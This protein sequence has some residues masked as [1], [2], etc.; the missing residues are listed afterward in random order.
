MNGRNIT[1]WPFFFYLRHEYSGNAFRSLH[2]STALCFGNEYTQ[3]LFTSGFL[4]IQLV[5]EFFTQNR[6]LWPRYSD[7]AIQFSV[8]RKKK[9]FST[10]IVMIVMYLYNNGTM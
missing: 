4:V 10:N 8:T 9:L 5:K 1:P 6:S 3:S 2:R 7:F